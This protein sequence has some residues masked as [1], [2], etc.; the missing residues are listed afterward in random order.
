MP[1]LEQVP[2]GCVCQRIDVSH[3]AMRWRAPELWL[4]AV[5]ARFRG[6]GT[7]LSRL[8]IEDDR[9]LDE[10]LLRRGYRS[11]TELGFLYPLSAGFSIT[12]S[13][14]ADRV[15]LQ[16]VFANDDWEVKE[17]LHGDTVM[18]PDGYPCDAKQW[19]Q[20]E[21]TKC[22]AGAMHCYLIRTAAGEL[23]GAIGTMRAGSVLR[24]KN[25]VV[26][27]QFRGQGMGLAALGALFGVARQLG[28]SALGVF[29]IE[30]EPGSALYRRAGFHV[31][32]HQ[33]EWTKSLEEED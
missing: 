13:L 25:V 10:L 16:P 29:G 7:P 4:D 2:A 11:R 22:F 6:L 23:C 5:E 33:V 12:S 17:A 3:I 27:P 20:L 19:V 15:S 31:E 14:G 8:Y 30:G 32:T 1:S 21:R 9:D 18:G 28:L 26:H 24:I